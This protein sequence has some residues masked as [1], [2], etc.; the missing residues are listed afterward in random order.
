MSAPATTVLEARTT[1][2]IYLDVVGADPIVMP[3]SRIG[4]TFHP[5]ALRLSYV[6]TND[7]PWQFD[8]GRVSGPAIRK[9]GSDGKNTSDITIWRQDATNSRLPSWITDAIPAH[10]PDQPYRMS[11]PV[12][13]S[14]P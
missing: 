3:Y 5:T 11:P 8:S 2:A 10:Q 7:G 13:M 14:Q 12:R 6:R 4:A 9:D 1:V